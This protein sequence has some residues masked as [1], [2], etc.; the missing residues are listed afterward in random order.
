MLVI[1]STV[2]AATPTLSAQGATVGVGQTVAIPISLS[3]ASNGVSG[4]AITVTLSNPGVASIEAVDLP[5]FGLTSIVQNSSSE[6]VIWAADLNSL[7]QSGAVNPTLSTL[8]MQTL[9]TGSTDIL[10]SVAVLDDDGGSAIGAA[11]LTSTLSVKKKV[12]GSGGGGG[13]KGGSGGGGGKG[14]G[15]KGKNK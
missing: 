7:I 13:G 9:K 15:G 3:E 14:G 4:Y 11:V 5:D 8:T 12:G 2:E 6:V 10:I 1:W